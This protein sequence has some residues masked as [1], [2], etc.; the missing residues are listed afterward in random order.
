MDNYLEKAMEEAPIISIEDAINE[1]G[2]ISEKFK[3]AMEA[4][5][6][7]NQFNK[8]SDP[9][10]INKRI[11]SV[12]DITSS[13][14]KFSI[15]QSPYSCPDN[16]EYIIKYL[17]SKLKEKVEWDNLG[18]AEL[19]LSDIEKLLYDILYE[20][21][22][23]EFDDWNVSKKGK[24]DFVFVTAFSKPD[25]DYDFI[26]LDALLRNVCVEIR[27]ERRKNDAFNKKFEE[28]YTAEY[29]HP[30]FEEKE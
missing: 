15:M 3:D 25:P 23:K 5:H 26:D 9:E 8:R 14:A 24:S 2:G 4:A 10:W 1:D 17:D 7:I 11:A 27:D 29:G 30:P 19:S 28:E 22:V 6:Q 13:F 18:Y 12:K 16:L 21:G 20:K